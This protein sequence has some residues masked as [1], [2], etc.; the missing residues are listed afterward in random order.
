MLNE[1]MIGLGSAP[2]D[3]RA[4]FAYGQARKAEIGEDKV[5]DYSIGNP[6]IPAPQEV[7][8]C[9]TRLLEEDPVALH[10]YSQSPGDP[11]CRQAVADHIK[12]HYGIDAKMEQIYITHGASSALAIT[13]K[14]ICSAGD[15]VIVPTPYFTEYKTWIESADA[16]IIEV[17]C[18]VPSFQLDVDAISAAINEKTVAIIVDSPNN[19]VGS[20]YRRDNL[21]ALAAML[22]AKE[23]EYGHA[24]YIVADEP[25]RAISYGIDIPYIPNLYKDTIVCYSFSKTLSLPGERI[26]YIY[27]SNL[28]DDVQNVTWA[29]Q[30]AGRALGYICASVLFQRVMAEC[31]ELPTDV[32][33]YR[34]NRELLTSGLKELGYEYVEPDGAFYLWVKALEP[35][36]KAFAE[37][38]KSFEI[39][40]CPSDGFGGQGY[41]RLSYCIAADTIKNSMPAFKKLKESYVA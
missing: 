31:I 9:I 4:L 35:D 27:V 25:Y 10:S 39:L 29:I 28:M 32:E 36:A 2:N 40:C 20:V 1:R 15:E 33:A 21:E 24:I 30:G 16:K 6:S 38:A 19:P 11:K 18:T 14:A 23:A 22:E 41:V 3:I 37:R 8:D 34:S 26:G 13:F 12:R 7:K 5:F 17:P